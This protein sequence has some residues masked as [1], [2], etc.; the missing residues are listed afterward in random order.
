MTRQMCRKICTS[1]YFVYFGLENGTDCFCGNFVD[2][3]KYVPIIEC[4][5]PCSGNPFEFCGGASKINIMKT[6]TKCEKERDHALALEATGMMGVFVPSCWTGQEFDQSWVVRA[7]KIIRVKILFL[8][9]SF[10][11]LGKFC[12]FFLDHF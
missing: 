4:T 3:A 6:L 11:L 12:S 7:R 9:E 2:K 5:K 10:F 8:L 1:G